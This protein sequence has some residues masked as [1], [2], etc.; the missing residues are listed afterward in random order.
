MDDGRVARARQSRQTNPPLN[1]DG[2]TTN[3]DVKVRVGVMHEGSRGGVQ[4]ALLSR[5]EKYYALY[6]VQLYARK[7]TSLY[8]SISR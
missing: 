3:C 7:P 8:F 1:A 2:F 5:T 6:D 4:V